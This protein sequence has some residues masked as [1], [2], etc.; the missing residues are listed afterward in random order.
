[1]LGYNFDKGSALLYG[2]TATT[3]W[4]KTQLE[5]IEIEDPESSV[6]YIRD[7]QRCHKAETRKNQTLPWLGPPRFGGKNII[8][9]DAPWKTRKPEHHVLPG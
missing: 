4:S 9:R 3:Y 2:T 8:L 1:M 7:S 5:D 6:K